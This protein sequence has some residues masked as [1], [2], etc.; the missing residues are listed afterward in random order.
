[1]C[2]VRYEVC[3]IQQCLSL[4][5]SPQ[6]HQLTEKKEHVGHRFRG[7]SPQ[8]LGFCVR[9]HNMTGV[10]S[11][12]EKHH[13]QEETSLS[14]AHLQTLVAAAHPTRVAVEKEP[15]LQSLLTQARVHCLDHSGGFLRQ[16]PL[17][18]AS[19]D[20]CNSVS[21]S[22]RLNTCRKQIGVVCLN[23]YK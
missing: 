3:C 23:M 18:S 5:L 1:M 13:S 11:S 9:Q 10:R 6:Y 21:I 17:R 20:M 4:I 12:V 15:D 8:P 2:D 7:P 14:H 22:I 16:D 19:A